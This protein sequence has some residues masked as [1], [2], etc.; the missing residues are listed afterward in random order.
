[1]DDDDRQKEKQ[2]DVVEKKGFQFVMKDKVLLV[3]IRGLLKLENYLFVIKLV[4][5]FLD[6][7]Y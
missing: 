3:S 5:I 7:N 1:M 4:T 2:I 6:K